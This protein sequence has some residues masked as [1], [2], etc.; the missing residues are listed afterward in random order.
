[1]ARLS[2]FIGLI[3]A[4][5][6]AALLIILLSGGNLAYGFTIAWALTAIV[7]ANSIMRGPYPAIVIAASAGALLALGGLLYAGHPHL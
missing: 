7:V 5:C 3:A 4:A 6:A 2:R 1:M